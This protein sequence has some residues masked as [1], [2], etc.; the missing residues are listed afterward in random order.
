[1]IQSILYRAEIMLQTAIAVVNATG[2]LLKV[3][4]KVIDKSKETYGT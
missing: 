2:M 3:I 1:M 4:R